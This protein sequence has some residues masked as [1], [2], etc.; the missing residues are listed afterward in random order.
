MKQLTINWTCWWHEKWK[1]LESQANWNAI[2]IKIEQECGFYHVTLN[3]EENRN[4]LLRLSDEPPWPSRARLRSSLCSYAH[5]VDLTPQCPR[6]L[7]HPRG[8]TNGFV[9]P[10]NP[11]PPPPLPRQP[12]SS[13]SLPPDTQQRRTLTFFRTLWKPTCSTSKV[14]CQTAEQSH[15][16]ALCCYTFSLF[17]ENALQNRGWSPCLGVLRRED[18]V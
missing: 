7:H 2:D 3:E 4:S 6:D 15:H 5:L 11:P 1:G 17:T 9:D 8:T 12:A 13:H 10:R 18:D 14:M 16:S